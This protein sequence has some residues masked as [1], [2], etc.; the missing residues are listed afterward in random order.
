MTR[1]LYLRRPRSKAVAAVELAVVLP[2]VCLLLFAIIEFGL[3]FKDALVL[4]QAVREACRAAIVGATPDRVDSI[5]R[6]KAVT[7]RPSDIEV[8]IEYRPPE[9]FGTSEWTPL[10]YDQEG[11][12]NDAPPGS[13]IRVSARYN[14]TLVTGGLVAAALGVDNSDGIPLSAASVMRRE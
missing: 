6:S 2:L 7:L 9:A 10:G 4:Q 13:Q 3:I 11:A 5:L 8:T 1:Q 12:H 14:H